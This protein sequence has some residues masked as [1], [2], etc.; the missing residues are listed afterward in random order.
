VTFADPN[1]VDTTASF[2]GT[3]TY[4]LRLTANDGELV[5]NDEVPVAV[6]GAGGGGDEGASGGGCSLA[7]T[8][9][10]R[11]SSLATLILLLIPLLI[12]LGL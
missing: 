3:G 8:K 2:S 7:P 10:S 11:D 5:S 12:V 6:I 4:L 1:A 9:Y